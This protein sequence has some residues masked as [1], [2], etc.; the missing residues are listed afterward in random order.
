MEAPLEAF[1]SASNRTMLSDPM[2]MTSIML[3]AANEGYGCDQAFLDTSL[4]G[5]GRKGVRDGAYPFKHPTFGGV[6]LD[7]QHRGRELGQDD[8]MAAKRRRELLVRKRKAL[9]LLEPLPTSGPLPPDDLSRAKGK[10]GRPGSNRDRDIF[11]PITSFLLG[12]L[13]L[14]P[15]L[16]LPLKRKR[17]DDDDAIGRNPATSL[18]RAAFLAIA[19]F[20]GQVLSLIEV[21]G[22]IIAE[23]GRGYLTDGRARLDSP[24][25]RRQVAGPCDVQ[26]QLEEQIFAAETERSRTPGDI[27]ALSAGITSVEVCGGQRR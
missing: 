22:R 20:L 19:F 21:G 11:Q 6:A 8:C 14:G 15:F 27:E 18:L 1:V 7:N 25:V 16:F 4:T 12:R 10:T 23:I 3:F 26:S 2:L 9:P 24:G 5:A 17:L 13:A